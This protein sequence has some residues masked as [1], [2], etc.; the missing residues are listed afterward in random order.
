MVLAALYFVNAIAN[1]FQ[2]SYRFGPVSAA[3]VIQL[4]KLTLAGAR[5]LRNFFWHFAHTSSHFWMPDLVMRTSVYNLPAFMS[6]F[7]SH[8]FNIDY[9]ENW[10]PVGERNEKKN[11]LLFFKEYKI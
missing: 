3:G 10:S 4:R 9:H 2:R 6:R 1:A 11:R 5:S 7:C 8:I